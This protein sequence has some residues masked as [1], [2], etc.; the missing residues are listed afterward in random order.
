MRAPLSH[1]IHAGKLAAYELP[2]RNYL[3]VQ[4]DGR[5]TFCYPMQC[6]TLLSITRHAARMMAEAR[7][8][9]T[10]K[11][12]ALTRASDFL[13]AR[14]AEMD[15]VERQWDA[16]LKA[17]RS[18]SDAFWSAQPAPIGAPNDPQRVSA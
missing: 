7:K 6:G 5:V 3:E 9:R 11:A 12:S 17:Q 8:A 2:L 13:N 15:L 14:L 4:P 18:A 16:V 10:G 1:L